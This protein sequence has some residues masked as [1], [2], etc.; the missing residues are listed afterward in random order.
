VAKRYAIKKANWFAS[1]AGF[2]IATKVQNRFGRKYI[3]SAKA[4]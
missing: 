2:A 4:S 1:K 3:N